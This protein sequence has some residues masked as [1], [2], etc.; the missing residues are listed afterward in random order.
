[1]KVKKLVKEFDALL[2]S[3]DRQRQRDE[4]QRKLYLRNAKA[5]KKVVL[6]QLKNEDD[7]ANRKKLKRELHAIERTYALLGA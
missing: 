1:M 5:N 3:I 2:G 6:K 7:K 4:Q